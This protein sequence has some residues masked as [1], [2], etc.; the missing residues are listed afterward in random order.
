MIV[1]YFDEDVKVSLEWVDVLNSY[2]I[3]TKVN[4]WSLSK[5]KKY[6]SVFAEILNTLEK[7]GVTKIYAIPPSEKEE[8]WEE[9]F[10]FKDSGLRIGQYKI[11]ELDYGN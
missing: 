10:G 9:L 3:H 11:M 8:K 2:A 1:V 6:L 5:Y 7:E 4:E